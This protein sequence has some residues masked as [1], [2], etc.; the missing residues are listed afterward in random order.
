MEKTMT[1]QEKSEPVIEAVIN[2]FAKPFQLALTVLSLLERS[3]RH[4]SAIW[5]Q[6]EPIASKYDSITPYYIADYISG[7]PRID[8]RV[9]QPSFWL[10]REAATLEKMADPAYREAIRYQFAFENSNA[11]LLYLS[12]NDIFYLRDLVGALKENIGDAFAIGQIGQCWNCPASNAE[13]MAETNGRPPC[14]PDAYTDFQPDFTGLRKLYA[15]ARGKNIFVR[16]YDNNNFSPEFEK[17]PWPLPECRV[18]E[19][20]CLLDLQKTRPHTIPFGSAWPPGAYRLCSGHNLDVITPWFR[21]MHALGMR[22]KHFNIYPYM[23]HWVG[24]GNKSALKYSQS[25]DNARRLLCRHYPEYIEWLEKK[26]GKK[27]T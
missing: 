2:N 15:A 16:P 3:G 12:H 23:K 22:A 8:C 5:L 20:A 11:D 6:F 19:W 9:S 27:F 4:L 26:T 1:M 21:D 18:N 14:S 13:I 24:T 17:R 10:A 7:M 25:E